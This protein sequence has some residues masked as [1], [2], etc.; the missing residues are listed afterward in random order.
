MP[1][2][3]AEADRPVPKEAP[4]PA[5]SKRGSNLK[6]IASSPTES[7][8]DVTE[9]RIADLSDVGRHIPRPIS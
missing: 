3:G 7:D 8:L 2:D 6:L 5:V 4:K 9:A 1:L